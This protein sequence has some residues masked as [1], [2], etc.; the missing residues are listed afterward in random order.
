MAKTKPPVCAQTDE[1][2]T[3]SAQPVVFLA[4]DGRDGE[5]TC[6]RCAA[7][8]HLWAGFYRCRCCGYKES[9]CF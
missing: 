5:Q 8:M 7:Q 6:P 3:D 1:E 2:A 9:C 4:D